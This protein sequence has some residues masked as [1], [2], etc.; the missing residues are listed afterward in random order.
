MTEDKSVITRMNQRN[1]KAPW[2][3]DFPQFKQDVF[4]ESSG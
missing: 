1:P 4:G 3:A 2:N